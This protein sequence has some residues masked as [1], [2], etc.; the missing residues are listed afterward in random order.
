MLGEDALDRVAA[1]L[2]P[3]VAERAPDPRIA[4]TGVLTGE[5]D[6]QALQRDAC[7]RSA[8]TALGRAVVLLRDQLAV[9]AQDRVGCD[10]AS[11]LFQDAAAQESTGHREPAA[12]CIREAQASIAD[13]LA[14]HTVLLLEVRDDVALAPVQPAREHDQQERRDPTCRLILPYG[15]AVSAASTR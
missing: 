14:Q 8:A 13:L 6:D 10:Q 11:K 7:A 3:E 2:V 1:E 15:G 9:P 4:P 5:P 12:L